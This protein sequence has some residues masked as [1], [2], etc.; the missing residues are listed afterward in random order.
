MRGSFFFQKEKNAFLCKFEK[1]LSRKKTHFLTS[2]IYVYSTFYVLCSRHKNTVNCASN[3]IRCMYVCGD[4]NSW[5]RVT[6]ESHEHW[7]PA[8]IDDYTGN[9]TQHRRI[10]P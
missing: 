7:S 3:E 6:R 4:G 1:L 5:A 9:F 10:I 8:S 2:P